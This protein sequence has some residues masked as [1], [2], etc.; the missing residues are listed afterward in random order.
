MR[1]IIIGVMG[2]GD[3]AIST[4]FKSAY[5]LGKLISQQGWVFLIEG[6]NVGFMNVAS[7]GT[8]ESGGSTIG[9]FPS[10]N[11][12]NILVA[13]D[14]AIITDLGNA[15]NNINVLSPEKS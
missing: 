1:K 15:R 9:I 5:Q 3:N 12:D 6:T 13:V 11:T 10:N 4:D 2:P 14:I 8:I 7:K